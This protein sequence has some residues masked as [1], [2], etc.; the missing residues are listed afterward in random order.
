MKG[1][2]RTVRFFRPVMGMRFLQRALL[3]TSAGGA[4]LLKI[5]FSIERRGL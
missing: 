5:P 3:P 2:D 1:P 4:V